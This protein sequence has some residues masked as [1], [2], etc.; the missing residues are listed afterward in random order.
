MASTQEKVKRVRNEYDEEDEVVK[1]KKIPRTLVEKD[2]GKRLIIILENAS[3]ETIKVNDPL[4][5][6]QRSLCN[7]HGVGGHYI[8]S[9]VT[10]WSIVGLGIGWN[11][12]IDYH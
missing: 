4:H 10:D 8:T 1:P 6:S 11:F 3:L 9:L 7:H 12:N 2:S 5:R